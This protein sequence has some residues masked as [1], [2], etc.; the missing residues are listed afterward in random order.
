MAAQVITRKVELDSAYAQSV[1][2]INDENLRV[3]DNQIDADFHARGHLVTLT[4]PDHEVARAVKVLEELES[5]A[6]RGHVISPDAVKHAV[7]IVT[8]E[9][10]QSVAEVLASD[11]VSRRGRTIRAKTLGQKEYVDAI[12]EHTIVFGVGPAG[13]GKTYLA[14]AKAVQALQSKQVTRIILTRPA[15]EA[16]E[17]LGFLP[18]TLSDKI[19]PYLRPLYDALR[20]M[21][22]PEMIPKLMDAGVIEVAPLAYMRGRTLNDAFVILDEA[23]NT[24]PAQMK[25]FLTRLGFGSKMIVTGDIT[26]VDLPTGQKSGLRLVR[27]IL[28]GVEGI[29]FAELT[30]QDVVR[31]SLVG[32]IV[33]AYDAFEEKQ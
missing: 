29:H 1:L 19:D 5:I 12:D 2:G 16:G 18:G 20:D 8:V 26:Q 10:P 30:S 32:R 28:R 23:Q 7:S 24:T 22:D 15:V 31:H 4:G 9:A 11:I 21:L 17:K 14:V 25:M 33:D 13:S 6:R 27:Q 3:L